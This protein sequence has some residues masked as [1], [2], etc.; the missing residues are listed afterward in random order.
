MILL[1]VNCHKLNKQRVIIRFILVFLLLFVLM[2]PCRAT[3]SDQSSEELKRSKQ[4]NAR[5]VKLNNKGKHREALNLIKESLSI[6]QKH[7]APGHKKIGISFFNLGFTYM[8]LKDFPPAEKNMKKGIDILEK[9]HGADHVLAGQML[10]Q[11]GNLYIQ[12]REFEKADQVLKRSVSILEKAGAKHK[13][14]L[15]RTLGFVALLYKRQAMYKEALAV[16]KR[17]LDIRT[18][19]KGPEHAD[20]VHTMKNIGWLHYRL[21]QYDRSKDYFSKALK[22]TEKKYGAGHLKNALFLGNLAYVHKA[23]KEY[24][25]AL[26]LY[27]KA[28][29]IY[30]KHLK[31]D[32][33]RIGRLLTE[34]AEVH[35]KMKNFNEAEKLLKEA[36]K[37]YE[38]HPAENANRLINTMGKI[39]GVYLSIKDYSR[40]EQFWNKALELARKTYGKDHVNVS[41]RLND[42]SQLYS[43][44]RSYKKAIS[45]LNEAA[46][47]LEKSPA[48]NAKDL[49][50]TYYYLGLN[51][52]RNEQYDPGIKYYKK[53]LALREKSLVP[54]DEDTILTMMKL[55]GLKEKTGGL[56]A[57]EKIYLEAL[58]RSRKYM[59]DYNDYTAHAMNRLGSMY[60]AVYEYDKAEQMLN[61]ALAIKERMYGKDHPET[62]DVHLNLSKYLSNKADMYEARSH[63]ETAAV[64]LE[65]EQGEPSTNL[66]RVYDELAGILGFMAEYERA[67]ELHD[68][69]L[70]LA[71]R[72]YGRDH[73]TTADMIK[74]K[75]KYLA[76]LGDKT[77]AEELL[78]ESLDIKTKIYGKDHPQVTPILNDM[79]MLYRDKPEKSLPLLERSYFIRVKASGKNHPALIIDM[80]RLVTLYGLKGDQEKA[81]EYLEKIQSMTK[82]LPSRHPLKIVGLFSTAMYYTSR[83]EYLKASPYF[84]ELK[85]FFEK[86]I[87]PDCHFVGQLIA[88][89]ALVETSQK[90]Y[91]KAHELFT[92]MVDIQDE[93]IDKIL[94]FTSESQKIKYIKQMEKSLHAYLSN[95][96][97]NLKDDPRALQ[98]GLDAWLRRKGIVLDAQKRFQ[99]ALIYGDDKEVFIIFEELSR[100]RA[101]ISRLAFSAQYMVQ[102]EKVNK[103]ISQLEARKRELES[104]LSKLSRSYA[105]AKKVARADSG[106]VAAALPADSVLIEFVRIRIADFKHVYKNWKPERYMAFILHSGKNKGLHLVDLGPALSVDQ[107]V[108]AFKKAATDPDDIEGLEVGLA[109]AG[110]YDKV[111]APILPKLE[112]KRRVF[113]APDGNLNLIPF[114]TLPT[115]DGRYLIDDFTFNYV[116]SGRD[117]LGFGTRK[118]KRGK[119]VLIGDPLFDLSPKKKKSVLRKIKIDQ[120][121]KKSDFRK[122][123]KL[124]SLT[125]SQLHGTREEV[126]ALTR[127]L[128]KSSVKSYLGPHALEEVLFRSDSP[129]ILHMATHGFFL[130]DLA[131]QTADDQRSILD[132]GSILGTEEMPGPGHFDNPLLL[133]GLALAG[134]NKSLGAIDSEISDGLLTAEK[135][136]GLKL[137]KTSLVV[138]S[139]CETG[140][141]Q[142]R[143]GEGVYGL[144]RAFT[145]AGAQGMVMS[146]WS[147]PD[148]ETKELMV[149]MYR[150][151]KTGKLDRC[152][153]L[154]QAALAQKKITEERFGYA[155]PLFWGGF[156]FLGE[157]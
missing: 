138:L 17:Q 133:S 136:L 66:I 101:R 12:T 126:A 107:A 25:K 23:V 90:R 100:V 76:T 11:L 127:I 128:G 50:Y 134:A 39:G 40:C 44:Q 118:S 94:G 45:L 105:S 84:N 47:I 34:L 96:L 60:A 75:A 155:H 81:K 102:P 72:N 56:R 16:Y 93:Q 156:I 146:M 113:I 7:L 143:N 79:A 20:C 103:L 57:S 4:L 142:V 104:K 135:V 78:Q 85:S 63:L 8:M 71:E 13:S 43:A 119:A 69:A 51:H 125:F 149:A 35:S 129:Y 77:R 131:L 36:L 86:L 33:A 52:G 42:L 154:R 97:L 70:Q 108:E 115:P 21:K 150:N 58:S 140:L 9:K 31:K 49:A 141:G 117:V 54:G 32:D 27:E 48:E 91:A 74:S 14:G 121:E 144:R 22:I 151:L 98:Q 5:A 64:I 124:R 55:A 10:C 24:E 37:I 137:N 110:L 61:E 147:V 130:E 80:G 6:W 67:G 87:G 112:D 62:A 53:S 38:M 29:T 26:P 68:K 152:Q 2:A 145:Q 122:S 30:R 92:K 132:A 1:K 46:S 123:E 95:V 82:M 116:N 59:G 157:P 73:S 148:L 15:A 109:G 111:F 41:Y 65:K 153:S 139:A 120:K 19:T 99:E 28:L 88:A 18:K 3:A 114:E 106:K 83:G 89:Q